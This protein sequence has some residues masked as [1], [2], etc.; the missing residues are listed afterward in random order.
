M[1]HADYVAHLKTQYTAAHAALV[2]ND[3]VAPVPNCPQWTV[4]DL[5]KHLAGTHSWAL[6]ALSTP[7]DGAWPAIPDRPDA[8]DDLVPWWEG[9]FAELADTLERLGPDAPAWTFVP[10]KKSGVWARRQAHETGIHHLDALSARDAEAPA[11]LFDPEFAADGV[12]EYLTWILPLAAERI[13]IEVE[14]RVLLHAA[15]AGRTWE[16]VVGP[17]RKP[18]VHA[19]T[20]SGTDADATVAGTADAVYRAVWGRPGGAIVSGDRRLFDGLPRP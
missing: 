6:T 17:D 18:S 1:E 5:V 13:P 16:V 14:G 7:P 4:F 11:L 10:E 2:T 15:D 12:D 8:W 9:K 19:V 20:G 3:P